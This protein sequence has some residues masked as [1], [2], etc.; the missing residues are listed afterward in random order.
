PADAAIEAARAAV[1]SAAHP[2]ADKARVDADIDNPKADSRKSLLGGLAQAVRRSKPDAQATAVTEDFKIE[3]S[4]LLEL[5]TQAAATQPEVKNEE[6]RVDQ[7]LAAMPDLNA[8]IRR[9]RDEQRNRG[10]DQPASS[11]KS[12]LISAARRAAQAAADETG[13][14]RDQEQ[15]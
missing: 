6:I 9:V 15:T 10:S 14:L 8:I 2:V 12:D 5:D 3:A 7:T 13:R 11:G 4:D 1:K